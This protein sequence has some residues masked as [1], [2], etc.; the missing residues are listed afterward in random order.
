L[1]LLG[2]INSYKKIKRT[3]LSLSFSD[4]LLNILFCSIVEF[5]FC[6]YGYKAFISIHERYNSVLTMKNTAMGRSNAHLIWKME[7]C[8]QSRTTYVYKARQGWGIVRKTI[9]GLNLLFS[10]T[11]CKRISLLSPFKLLYLIALKKK[12]VGM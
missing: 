5:L 7:N 8:G 1:I 3:S 10:W 12:P 4:Y 6:M 9:Q 11:N 2:F